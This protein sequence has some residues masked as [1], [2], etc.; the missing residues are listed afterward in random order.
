MLGKIQ[1]A[2]NDN[3]PRKLCVQRLNLEPKIV[4]MTLDKENKKVFE[5]LTYEKA[6]QE[7][8]GILNSRDKSSSLAMLTRFMPENEARILLGI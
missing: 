3:I 5:S 1:N 4:R 2:V 7:Y 8:G 6:V